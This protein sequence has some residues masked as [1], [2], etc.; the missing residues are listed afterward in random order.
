MENATTAEAVEATEVT[1]DGIPPSVL[2]KKRRARF[3][4]RKFL[5][6]LFIVCML[7]YPVFQFVVMWAFVNV[8]SILMTF[9]KYDNLEG[10]H[11]VGLEN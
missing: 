9:Q 7:A 5:R 1:D 2:R 10:W 3:S 6:G 4:K 8:D 11:W